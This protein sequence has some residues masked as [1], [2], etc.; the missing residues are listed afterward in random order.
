MHRLLPV[1]VLLIFL[2]GAG[3]EK[4]DQAF[5]AVDKAK[6]IKTDVEKKFNDTKKDLTGKAEEITQKISKDLPVVPLKEGKEKK[7]SDHE[8]KQEKEDKK[9]HDD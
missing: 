7:S 1:V 5:E 2:A 8:G 9:R 4:V 3:C 6:A